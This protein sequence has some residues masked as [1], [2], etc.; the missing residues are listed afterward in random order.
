MA[1]ATSVQD[2]FAAMPARYQA[3]PPGD[4]QA[5]IQFELSGEGGGQYAVTFAGATCSVQPGPAPAPTL[6]YS[7]TAADFLSL[8]NGELNP[9]AAFM[10][11]KLQLKGDVSLAL[12]LQG[13]FGA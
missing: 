5:V 8:V 1:R 9:M 12:K 6:I 13:V 4:L 10:Q 3:A 11:G 2:V 7:S